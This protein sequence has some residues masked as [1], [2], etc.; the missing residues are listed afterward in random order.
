M[1]PKHQL[2]LDPVHVSPEP[3]GILDD[4]LPVLP[5]N[6]VGNVRYRSFS[7]LLWDEF[8]RHLGP[9]VSYMPGLVLQRELCVATRFLLRGE[10][11]RLDVSKLGHGKPA[12]DVDGS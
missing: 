7:L 6:E 8:V 5:I 9:Q 4:N 2:P 12:I 3:L 1:A 10:P 11:V